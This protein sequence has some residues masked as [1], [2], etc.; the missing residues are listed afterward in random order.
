MNVGQNQS[1]TDRPSDRVRGA[2]EP[3]V[4]IFF[5][6]NIAGLT[7]YGS[8]ALSMMMILVGFF[9]GDP[10]VMLASLFPMALAAYHLPIRR[11]DHPQI[12]VTD[13]GLFLDGLGVIPWRETTDVDLWGPESEET[14]GENELVVTTKH[15]IEFTIEPQMDLTLFRTFQVMV[16]RLEELNVIR[17]RLEPLNVEP[18]FLAGEARR[19]LRRSRNWIH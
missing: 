9:S 12:V 1:G 10:V 7:I 8:G 18:A 14:D 15:A 2:A 3:P 19:R 17:I 5:L 11:N 13:H 4:R 6:D 16:W